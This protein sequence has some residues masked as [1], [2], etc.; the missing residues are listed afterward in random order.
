MDDL[1]RTLIGSAV[2]AS[3]ISYLGVQGTNRLKYITEERSLWRKD[4]RKIS[5]NLEY[6]TDINTYAESISKLKPMLNPYGK[7]N[8][9]LTQKSNKS[10]KS[11]KY[12]LWDGYIW[13]DINLIET[14][15]YSSPDFNKAN[16]NLVQRLDLLLKYDWERAKDE[17]KL[18]HPLLVLTLSFYGILILL[19]HIPFFNST[20]DC[21]YVISFLFLL[22]VM[23]FFLVI[24]I[25]D[26]QNKNE[27]KKNY[28]QANNNL[29]IPPE[30]Q[31]KRAK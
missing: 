2:I 16:K 25:K 7:D 27:T 1:I 4:L 19:W 15:S 8:L 10:E 13:N 18:K 31:G 21:Y 14:Y 30:E 23:I 5:A 12:I 26:L 6:S 22:I 11:E 3:I 28:I 17:T 24:S 9:L 29:D 20:I